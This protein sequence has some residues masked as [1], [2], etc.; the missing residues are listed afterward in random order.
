MSFTAKQHEVEEGVRK[1]LTIDPYVAEGPKYNR[2]CLLYWCH[3]DRV[4]TYDRESGYYYTDPERFEEATSPE[5]ISRA[6]R[7]LVDKAVAKLSPK[8]EE[9][10]RELQEKHRLYAIGDDPDAETDTVIDHRRRKNGV[11]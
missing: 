8:T 11:S 2:L 4:V 10:R 7:R 6:F 1:V 5:S 3:V 9:R